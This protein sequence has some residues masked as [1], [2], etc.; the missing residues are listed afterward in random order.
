M[1]WLVW[2][3]III[4]VPAIWVRVAPSSVQEWHL[5][6]INADAPKRL[7]YLTRVSFSDT[8]QDTLTRIDKIARSTPRTRVLAGNVTEGRITYVTRSL[9]WGFPDYTTIIVEN[10]DEG[11]VLTIYGRLRFGLGDSGVN[12]ARIKS[13]LERMDALNP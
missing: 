2:V 10:K 12:R 4:A 13:W 7:G 1:K 5:T 9:I 6:A 11:S 8:A 3:L